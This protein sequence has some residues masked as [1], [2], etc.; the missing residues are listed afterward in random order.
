M[1]NDSPE[2]D[3]TDYLE[4]NY[5]PAKTHVFMN[6]SSEFGLWGYIFGMNFEGVEYFQIKY[7]EFYFW[8]RKL[9]DLN[10][11]DKENSININTNEGL[12]TAY[13]I[14]L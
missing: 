3:F 10:P 9:I 11:T 4:N 8:I 6:A 7:S 13:S 14:Q 5:R 2:M 12:L 1:I